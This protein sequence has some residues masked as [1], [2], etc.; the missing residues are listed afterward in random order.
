MGSKFFPEGRLG[1]T[2]CLLHTAEL[3]ARNQDEVVIKSEPLS[4][5]TLAVKQGKKDINHIT[6]QL[7]VKTHQ[8]LALPRK[9]TCYHRNMWRGDLVVLDLG[10][11]SNI[12]DREKSLS[13]GWV[14][15]LQESARKPVKL[16]SESGEGQGVA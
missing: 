7:Q 2:S 8:G 3:H 9:G 11:E 4:L 14:L 6:P 13:K 10:V 16:D 5:T 12:Q 1:G 15:S